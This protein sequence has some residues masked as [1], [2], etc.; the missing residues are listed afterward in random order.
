MLKTL[1][2][3]LASSYRLPLALAFAVGLGVATIVMTFFPDFGKG[4]DP[5]FLLLLTF[6][7]PMVVVAIGLMVWA[8]GWRRRRA[9]ARTSGR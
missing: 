4:Q 8:R 7:F 3:Y 9:G 2:D 6:V 5:G 1:A